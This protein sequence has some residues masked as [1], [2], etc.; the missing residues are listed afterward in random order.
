M[1]I[2]VEEILFEHNAD[3]L[4]RNTW[5]SCR[6][7]SKTLNKYLMT[8]KFGYTQIYHTKI[9]LARKLD[10]AAE[11]AQQIISPER[12]T[13]T[14]QRCCSLHCNS[15]LEAQT[16]IWIPR[17][18]VLYVVCTESCLHDVKKALSTIH[19]RNRQEYAVCLHNK[20]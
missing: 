13:L 8:R 4:H 3:N 17:H 12:W 9:R 15:K 14:N 16:D 5:C 18:V 7:A 6:A 10:E 19:W 20:W 11:I 1:V 2:A